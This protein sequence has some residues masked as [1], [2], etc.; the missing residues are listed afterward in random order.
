MTWLFAA[1]LLYLVA[2]L[3]TTQL[4]SWR[5]RS[6]SA[7]VEPTRSP[8][9]VTLIKPVKG[10]TEHTFESFRSWLDQEYDAEIQVLFCLQDE[11]DPALE[12][13]DR[14]SKSS[15]R[16]RFEV[17][18]SPIR[19]GYHGKTSNQLTGVTHARHDILIF[20]DADMEA[21]PGFLA[22]LVGALQCG[23]GIVSCPVVHDRA[24]SLGGRIYAILWNWSI[25]YA[26][27]PGLLYSVG[28]AS[29]VGGTVIMTRETLRSLGGIEAIAGYAGDDVAMAQIAADKGIQRACGPTLTSPVGALGMGETLEK[30]RR[31]MSGTR[32]VGMW[33][34]AGILIAVITAL[35]WVMVAFAVLGHDPLHGLFAS[36]FIALRLVYTREVVRLGGG[37]A[38]EAALFVPLDLW[39]IVSAIL[40]VR[41]PEFTWGGQRL[42]I[43]SNGKIRPL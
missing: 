22:R 2:L 19:D 20:S 18:V 7:A 26:F 43:E 9:P 16:H 15:T 5:L 42:R 32:Q 13:L 6:V 38:W 11:R 21:P 40:T 29:V 14:L 31:I 41:S 3:S 1:Y 10:A 8:V 35:P 17:H 24:T 25:F 39:M 12:V 33:P 34:L 4:L 36:S 37:G 28:P 23:G 27:A 30:F